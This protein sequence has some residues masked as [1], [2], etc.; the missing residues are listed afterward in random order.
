MDFRIKV[1]LD[2]NQNLNFRRHVHVPVVGNSTGVVNPELLTSLPPLSG[3]GL[4]V[5]FAAIAY[6]WA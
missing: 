4:L 1:A 5:N 3:G 6:K 2:N